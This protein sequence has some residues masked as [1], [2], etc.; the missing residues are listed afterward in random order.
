MFEAAELGR[1]LSKQEFDQIEPDLHTALLAAQRSLRETDIPVIL[2]VSGVEGAGK[3]E[4]VNRLNKWLDTRG[5]MTTAFWDESDEE[6]ERPAYWRF[7]RRLPPKGNIGIMFGSWYILPIIDFVFGRIDDAEY[8]KRLQRIWNFEH[9]LSEDGALIIK[10]WFHLSE[11]NQR[12][13]LEK[14]NKDHK[15]TPILKK[16]SKHYKDFAKTSEYAIRM[17]DQGG[18]PWHIIEADDK[19]YRDIT[20]GKIIHDALVTRIQK[21]SDKPSDLTVN[22]ESIISKICKDLTVLDGVDINK[23]TTE[24]NYE[25]QLKKYQKKL[26]ALSWEARKQNRSTIAMFEGWDAAGKGGA[27][28]RMTA[29]IDA[30]LYKTISVAAPTDEEKA[31]HYLWRFWRHIPR[32]GYVTIYDRSWYGRVLVERVE[33][34]AHPIEWNR[35]YQEINEF[36][37]QLVESGII[38]CKFWIHITK[39]EQLRRFKEREKTPWKVHKITDED[40]RN[41]DK[42]DNYKHAINDMVIHT[43]TEYAPWSL[44][45][46]N[47]K[48]VARVEVLKTVCDTLEASLDT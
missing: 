29:C 45:P 33:G 6:R 36:E 21:Q 1:K 22:E 7:W 23:K 11:K 24:K 5:I 14:E 42:W 32:A 30:R 48:R 20:I 2:I 16:F 28:R 38:L 31:Q 27:I 17:T 19:L 35:A 13:K 9:M 8:E 18:S 34:F 25:K 37:E 15:Y 10:F 26:N 43:S 47:D 40:W 46:G 41:R 3:G 4:V 39:D 12:K 44:I